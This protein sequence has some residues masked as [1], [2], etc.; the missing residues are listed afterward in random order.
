MIKKYSYRNTE[1]KEKHEDGLVFQK[2]LR[3]NRN[4]FEGFKCAC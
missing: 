1:Q 3:G 4:V 2:F